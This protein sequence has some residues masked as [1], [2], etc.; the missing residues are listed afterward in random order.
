[1]PET[2]HTP[3]NHIPNSERP[4]ERLETQG[5][6]ALSTRE[7]LAIVLGTGTKQENV[8]QLAERILAHFGGL[9]GL[10]K[11]TP[12]QLENIHGLGKA[13]SASLLAILE[14]SRR[15]MIASPDERPLIR[16]SEDAARLVMDMGTLHQE[17][18]RLILLDTSNR[19]IAMPTVYIGTVNTAV[20][21]VAELYREAIARNAPAMIVVHNHPSGDPS[22]S[23]EDVSL[24]RRLIEAGQ[25]LDII[26]IDHLIIGGYDWRSLR[27]MGLAFG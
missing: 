27:K 19:V 10:A 5:P 24:T 23:P 14:I 1:M 2:P 8:M 25:L 15:L 4:H 21:R 18:V 22:P 6:T 16:S 17:H 3:M 9:N 12:A 13:K 7:L 11:A 20:L 26:L